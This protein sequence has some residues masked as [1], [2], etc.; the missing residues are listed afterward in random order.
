MRVAGEEPVLQVV[1]PVFRASG[2]GQSGDD[3][4]ETASFA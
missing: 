1:H 3:L 2:V 4:V